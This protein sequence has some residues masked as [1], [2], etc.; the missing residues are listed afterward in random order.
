MEDLTKH[1]SISFSMT[2]NTTN[3]CLE[4]ILLIAPIY[5]QFA[6]EGWINTNILIVISSITNLE[7]GTPFY[8]WICHDITGP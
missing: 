1:P 3:M 4:T 8:K 2:S 5:S 6:H 7:I